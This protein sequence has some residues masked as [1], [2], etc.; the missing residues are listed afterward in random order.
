MVDG[1]AMVLGMVV[2]SVLW[3]SW[4]Q[5]VLQGPPP[6]ASGCCWVLVAFVLHELHT[7]LVAIT[8][9]LRVLRGVH[10][11]TYSKPKVGAGRSG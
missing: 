11:R 10:E 8:A 9:D 4:E 3:G 6:G 2:A 7:R 1:A 5:F